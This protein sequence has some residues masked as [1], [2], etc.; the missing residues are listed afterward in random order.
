MSLKS[1]YSKTFLELRH[2]IQV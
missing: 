2:E 1:C